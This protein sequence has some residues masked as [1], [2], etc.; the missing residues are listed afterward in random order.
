MLLI[1]QQVAVLRYLIAKSRDASDLAK[2]VAWILIERSKDLRCEVRID[3]PYG[4]SGFS[5][6]DIRSIVNGI[7][8][9]NS[10]NG[11]TH[12]SEILLGMRSRFTFSYRG[13]SF[14]EEGHYSWDGRG[15]NQGYC[16]W[17]ATDY[18]S[19]LAQRV[20]VTAAEIEAQDLGRPGLRPDLEPSEDSV[21]SSAVSAS[22]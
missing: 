5:E 13:G 2:K 12:L 17:L 18:Y 6:S 19:E 3:L 10:G 8:D 1:H 14:N 15:D 21:T 16:V 9:L 7:H 20:A 4:I 11:S 22:A